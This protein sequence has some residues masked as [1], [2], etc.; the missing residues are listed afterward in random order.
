MSLILT[1]VGILFIAAGAAA[2]YRKLQATVVPEDHVAITVSKHGFVKRVLP[3][4][5]HMLR[6]KERVELLLDTRTKLA[7]GSVTA[8]AAADG[9]A[10]RLSWSGTYA[11]RPEL[12][13]ESRSQRLRGLPNAERAIAR[14][15]DLALRR[16]VGGVTTPQLFNPAL[17]ERLERQ[18]SAG[19]AD[20][21]APLGI[22]LNGL[23]LQAIELPADVSEALNKANALSTLDQAI[24]QLDPAT[25]EIVRGVYQLDELLH[26]DEYLPVPSRHTMRR[27]SHSQA[28]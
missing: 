23:N 21:L 24:R 19:V 7:S 14:N 3:A 27:L 28:L 16:L 9:V 17:R 12:I 13:T 2:L 1:L 11:L 20:R 18:L 6:P 10:V 15:A 5:K 22:A 8:V 4:G 26:W 25:R